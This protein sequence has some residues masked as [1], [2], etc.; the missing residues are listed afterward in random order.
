[1]TNSTP[2][3]ILSDQISETPLKNSRKK[4]HSY[5]KSTMKTKEKTRESNTIYKRRKLRRK[6]IPF[7]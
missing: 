6:C 4:D 7:S 2:Q 3:S 1:M 5:E